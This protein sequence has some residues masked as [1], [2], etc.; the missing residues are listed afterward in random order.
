VATTRPVGRRKCCQQSTDDRRYSLADDTKRLYLCVQRDG[1]DARSTCVD[2]P[3]AAD[4]TCCRLRC[5]MFPSRK[6][7]CSSLDKTWENQSLFS[8][9]G[10]IVDIFVSATD[11]I[12]E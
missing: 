10:F 6:A 11:I 9:Q 5:I 7:D 4:E 12:S 3:S 1:R 8:G 2:R